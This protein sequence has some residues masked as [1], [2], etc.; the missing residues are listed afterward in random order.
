MMPLYFLHIRNGDKLE[1]DPDGTE[2][3]DVDAAFAEAL[4][5]ARELVDEVADLGRNAAIE[6]ADGS[7][8]TVLTVPFSEV[9]RPH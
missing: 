3:P 7:G 1:V 8:E 6:I 9:V 5:V 4:K 2:L